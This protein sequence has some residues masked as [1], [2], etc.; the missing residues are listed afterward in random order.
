MLLKDW[1]KEMASLAYVVDALELLTSAGRRV[2][3][4][5]QLTTNV[6]DL[7]REYDNVAV[8]VSVC[9]AADKRRHNEPDNAAQCECCDTP[10]HERKERGDG[11]GEAFVDLRHC[12][13]ELHD[14]HGTLQLLKSHTVLSEVDLFEVKRLAH[15]NARARVAA[16]A[17]GESLSSIMALPDLG[18]VFAL[19]DPDGT[20]VAHFYIYD[21]YDSRLAD[22][23]KQLRATDD[24]AV[25]TDLMAQHDA[26]QQ[27][28]MESLSAQLHPYS[29][30]LMQ[31]LER[32]AYTDILLA[33]AKLAIDWE[34]VR[35][36]LACDA[37]TCYEQLW[38]PRLRHHNEQQGLRYQPIDVELRSGLTLVSGA[39][40]SG[41]TVMLKTVALAQLMA[42]H[43]FYVPAAKATVS[44]VAA[45]ELCI[46]DG[47]DEMSGL[48]SFA[49]EIGRISHILSRS[50]SERLLILVDEPARTTNPVEGRAIVQA[51]CTLLSQGHGLAVVTTHY[52]GIV[53]Q[54]H[55]LRVRGFVED[56]ATVPLTPQSINRF[57]DYSL[58]EDSDTSVP[59]EALRIAALLGADSDLLAIAN[60]QLGV[61]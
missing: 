35:P 11:I 1:T 37:A 13:M 44:P 60:S 52:S 59:Q 57:I 24:A 50:R 28:V 36:V 25:K 8:A 41:K 34:L 3:L 4:A 49:W 39:N 10:Q 30:S 18:E 7:E 47:Q 9:K 45:V 29:N 54:C 38:E 46:G 33:K 22:L 27:Q 23:R 43:G 21:S 14:L 31:S 53:V 48:S 17:L 56:M 42:Q 32:L 5:Q 20:G 58:L 55:R 51:L 19:L 6:S 40:M 61:G 26:L 15:I 2:L 16:A 12:L